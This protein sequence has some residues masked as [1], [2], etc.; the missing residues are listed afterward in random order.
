MAEAQSSMVEDGLVDVLLLVT[1]DLPSDGNDEGELRGEV[2]S[3]VG[4]DVYLWMIIRE[5]GA[6]GMW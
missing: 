2:N 1:V 4:E 6:H 3:A 5:R